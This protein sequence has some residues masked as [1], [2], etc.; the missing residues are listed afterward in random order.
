MTHSSRTAKKHFGQHFLHDTSVIEKI[1]LAITPKLGEPTV[2]VGPGRGALTL[3]LLE[4]IGELDAIEI[5]IDV[6]PHLQTLCAKAGEL[7]LHRQDVLK[8]DFEKLSQQRGPLRVVGNLPYNISTPLMFHVLANRAGVRDCH[9]MVQKE[10]AHRIAAAP[11]GR[12]YGRLSVMIQY[13][14]AVTLLFNVKPGS[15]TPPP[16]VDSSVLRLVPYTQPPFPAADEA[17]FATLV[18]AAFQKRRKTLRNALK[19]WVTVEAI[20]SAK[21]DPTQR[22]ETLSV[23]DYVRLSNS[24]SP[25]T[26]PLPTVGDK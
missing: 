23:R 16:R 10:V 22:P 5:D 11:G 14:C 19:Q 7:R 12:E 26:A 21:L 2:E 1:L 13:A 25:E 9:F 4:A 8:F 17:W 3:P 15:F 18:N 24:T 6:I 20:E